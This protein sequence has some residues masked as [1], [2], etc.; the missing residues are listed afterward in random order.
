MLAVEGVRHRLRQGVVAQIHREHGTPGQR[1]QNNPVQPNGASEPQHQDKF[2]QSN[3]HGGNGR[4]LKGGCQ[5]GEDSDASRNLSIPPSNKL[6]RAGR[7]C[8]TFR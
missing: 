2:G 1:L 4:R 7:G 5:E 8:V 3:Q 6:D